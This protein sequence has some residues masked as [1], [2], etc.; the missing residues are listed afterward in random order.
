MALVTLKDKSSSRILKRVNVVNNEFEVFTT[1]TNAFE[2]FREEL[3]E[4]ELSNVYY[5]TMYKDRKKLEE[6]LSH[7][8]NLVDELEKNT[9]KLDNLCGNVYYP[10][11]DAN[12]KCRNYKSIYEQVVNYFVTDVNKYNKDVVEKFNKYQEEQGS[13]VRLGYYNTKKVYI[14]YNNDS[15]YDGKEE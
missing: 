7:Y 5:D 9:Y 3:Y 8:E 12:N 13:F 14:D 15:K 4:S 1:N 2:A 11:G 6:K 10:S